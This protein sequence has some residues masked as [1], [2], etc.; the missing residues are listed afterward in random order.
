MNTCSNS[1]QVR[2]TTPEKERGRAHP[3]VKGGALNW[4]RWTGWGE[5]APPMTGRVLAHS[6]LPPWAC[7]LRDR[8][9]VKVRM[10]MRMKMAGL[11]AQPA[12]RTRGAHT[13]KH[14]HGPHTYRALSRRLLCCHFRPESWLHI[15][16]PLLPTCVIPRGGHCLP[17]AAF[18][19]P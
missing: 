10:R 14:L 17:G 12:G 6:K 11:T 18:L 8:A 7:V 1:L 15:W 16:N 13:C 9:G 3:V 19:E 4:G 2:P 5:S